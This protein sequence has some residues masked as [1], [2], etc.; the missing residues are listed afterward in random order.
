MSLKDAYNVGDIRFHT[1]LL[2]N[3]LAVQRCGTICEDIYGVFPGYPVAQYPQQAKKI[4]SWLLQQMASLGNG[5]YQEFDNT[6]IQT[7]SLGALDY[8]SLASRNVMKTLMAQSLSSQ[9]DVDKRVVDTDGDSLPDSVD[10]PIDPAGWGTS[11]FDIDSDG[12]CFSDSEEVNRWN[13]GFRPTVPDSR[14]RPSTAAPGCPDTDGDGL[15]QY[16]ENF[17][18]TH[19]ALPDT[20]ADGLLD[21]LE[22]N[23]GLNPLQSNNGLDTDGD[24]IPDLVEVTAGSNPLKKDNAFFDELGYQ[25]ETHAEV[26]GDGSLCY[27][28]TISN[29]QLVTPPARAGVR[30]GYNLFR[31]LFSEAAESGIAT[32]YGVWKSGCA[33]ARYDPPG[34]RDPAGPE[35]TINDGNF[36]SLPTFLTPDDYVGNRCQGTSPAQ[37][38]R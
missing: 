12:D 36:Y 8:T 22:E 17:V 19:N 9:P 21:G 15:S 10:N 35:L 27:D 23:I 30:Q 13:Q 33:W 3:E 6:E 37:G 24:G 18:G 38:V 32:D 29:L 34:I 5:V 1:V 25:Y 26:Q 4:A 28:Y 20:D 14:G 11:R 7:L 31:V 2:F 16:A